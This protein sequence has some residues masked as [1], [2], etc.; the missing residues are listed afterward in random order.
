MDWAD[1]GM[2]DGTDLG[3]ASFLIP[4]SFNICNNLIPNTDSNIQE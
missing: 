2:D 4:T 1:D 3:E